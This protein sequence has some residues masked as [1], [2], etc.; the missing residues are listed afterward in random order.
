MKLGLLIV[1]QADASDE[2]QLGFQPVYVLLL[3]FQDI[4]EQVTADVIMDGLGI[5]DGRFQV[6]NGIHFQ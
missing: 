3:V 6:G 2:V 1:F 4:L 5:G